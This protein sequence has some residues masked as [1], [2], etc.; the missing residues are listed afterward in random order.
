M[1]WYLQ[2]HIYSEK[3]IF[4]YRN[5]SLCLWQSYISLYLQLESYISIFIIAHWEGFARTICSFHV[6][7]IFS[8]QLW[9]VQVL[10][11]EIWQV[12]HINVRWKSK[13]YLGGPLGWFYYLTTFN[14]FVN[15]QFD[16]GLSFICLLSELL[17]DTN[18]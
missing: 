10:L 9:Q 12:A 5:K 2:W 3:I 1:L 7:I 8:D 11:E 14:G 4:W 18:T 17:V 6:I 15:T 16:R 13:I